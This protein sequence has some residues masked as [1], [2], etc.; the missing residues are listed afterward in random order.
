A[1]HLDDL[2]TRNLVRLVGTPAVAAYAFGG[3]AYV[4]TYAVGADGRLKDFVFTNDGSG[5]ASRWNDLGTPNGVS[6]TYD[7][8]VAAYAVGGT[9]YV[10][11]YVV[12]GGGSLK[13]FVFT[14][15]GS[16]WAPHWNDL[17]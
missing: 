5:W 3:T 15:D 6:L 11:T 12:G 8:A 2:G 14:N 7:P 1:S 9:F 16:G 17:A 10:D 4:D 13:D